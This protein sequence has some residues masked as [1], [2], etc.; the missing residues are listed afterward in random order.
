MWRRDNWGNLY[1]LSNS[2]E[3]WTSRHRYIF[4]Y[5]IY[6]SAWYDNRCT[7]DTYVVR[8]IKDESY[9]DAAIPSISIDD[10]TNI[11]TSSADIKC[12]VSKQ[13]GSEISSRGL[14][15][16]QTPELTLENSE[17]I[18]SEGGTGEFTITLTELNGGTKYYVRAFAANE[19]GTAY[20]KVINFTT[21][22][23]GTYINLS[24]FETANS[25]IVS[26]ANKDYC[27][28]ASV[29]GNSN[30]SIGTPASADVIWET[31]NSLE[32]VTQCEIIKEVSLDGVFVT[33]SLP[34]VSTSGNALI[35]VKDSDGNILWSWHIWVTDFDPKATAQ[36]YISG[37]V[38]MDRNLGALSN[39]PGSFKS[40]GLMYQWGRKDPFVSSG[41]ESGTWA[42]TYPENAINALNYDSSIDTQDYATK[43]PNTVIYDSNWN[44]GNN[45]LWNS[46]KTM[47]DPCPAGWKVPDGG[48]KSVWSGMDPKSHNSLGVTIDPPYSL[49]ST[50]IPEAGRNNSYAIGYG[51]FYWNN[52]SIDWGDGGTLYMWY[53][54]QFSPTNSQ[55]KSNMQSIRCQNIEMERFIIDEA[56]IDYRKAD[57]QAVISSSVTVTKSGKSYEKGY[58]Y[59]TTSSAPVLGNGTKY[60]VTSEEF[61]MTLNNLQSSTVYYIT[62]YVICDGVVKYGQIS[63]FIT[64]A[65]GSGEDVTEDDDE[66]EW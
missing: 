2:G 47:Y 65:E 43:H 35:A 26:T 54:S 14:L 44:K 5:D 59:S 12:M 6:Q 21:E 49:P 17:A 28:N 52:N 27:F 29:K 16:G 20:S 50:Y 55:N 62:P 33:F 3:M 11:T 23:G 38:M 66:Y 30:I 37:A 36:T 48:D 34:E 63:K 57:K 46:N 58:I 41:D 32:S 13:G 60:P 9:V 4:A 18:I 7:S 19:F 64:D 51:G 22:Y 10:I 42:V 61:T 39:T 56:T 31:K 8:C 25:Y 53:G 15:F 24:T 40:F 45:N 1:I